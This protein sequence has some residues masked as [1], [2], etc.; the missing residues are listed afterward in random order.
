MFPFF[1]LV[2]TGGFGNLILAVTVGLVLHGAKDQEVEGAG[3]QVRKGSP[4]HGVEYR[5]YGR[6]VS[7]VNNSGFNLVH[8]AANRNITI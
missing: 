1:S 4:R 6:L 5:H 2:D 3:Q 7:A 8:P